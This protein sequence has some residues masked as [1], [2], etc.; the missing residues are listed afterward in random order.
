MTGDVLDF[1]AALLAWYGENA[2]DLPWRRTRDPYVV[3]VSEIMLQQTRVAAVVEYFDRFL[4]AFPTLEELDEAGG[5][6]VLGHGG[7]RG[8]VVRGRGVRWGGGG[9]WSTATPRRVRGQV[10][11]G[12][13]CKTV[14]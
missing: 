12:P 8:D 13:P 4:R 3:W 5:E 7:A 14:P 10:H 1:R 9:G 11:E 6:G 2:R